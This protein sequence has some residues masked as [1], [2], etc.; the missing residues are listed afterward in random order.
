MQP[1]STVIVLLTGSTSRIRFSRDSDSTTWVPLASTVAAPHMP[2]WPP[3]G[4]MAT[5]WRAQRRTT[6]ATSAVLPGRSTA[7]G[8]PKN[9]R[10]QSMAQASR[11]AVSTLAAPIAARAS[12]ISVA[13]MASGP[14]F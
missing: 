6:V 7:S 1:A 14:L 5:P 12:S 4:T 2:V 11:S 10:R 8:L 9:L 13:L 3:C